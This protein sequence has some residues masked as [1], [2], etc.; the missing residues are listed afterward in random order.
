M[1]RK[2]RATRTGLWSSGKQAGSLDSTGARVMSSTT[3]AHLLSHSEKHGGISPYTPQQPLLGCPL[4]AYEQSG[5]AGTLSSQT[6]PELTWRDWLA[7]A[8]ASTPLGAPRSPVDTGGIR[9]E[10]RGLDLS[11]LRE[12]VWALG[13]PFAAAGSQNSPHFSQRDP[14]GPLVGAGGSGQRIGP[15]TSH[16]GTVC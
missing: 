8:W 9:V 6:E 10:T 7:S 2:V 12:S 15:A 5:V 3:R 1:P 11:V 4:G 16:L 13:F 14:A